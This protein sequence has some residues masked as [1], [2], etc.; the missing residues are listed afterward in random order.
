MKCFRLN[1]LTRVSV[2][3]L[4]VKFQKRGGAVSAAEEQHRDARSDPREQLIEQ[5]FNE[6]LALAKDISKFLCC[7]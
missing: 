2:G 6:L 7:L 3:L 4:Q 5:C 1:V